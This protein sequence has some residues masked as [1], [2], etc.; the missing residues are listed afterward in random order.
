MF[1]R[2]DSSCYWWTSFWRAFDKRQRLQYSKNEW[3]E[4][5][6]WFCFSESS[7]ANFLQMTKQMSLFFQFK[8]TAGLRP[9]WKKSLPSSQKSSA[10]KI[11]WIKICSFFRAGIDDDCSCFCS[12][13]ESECCAFWWTVSNLDYGRWSLVRL[14]NCLKM[15]EL[16]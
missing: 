11:F 12:Y 8:I 3:T 9:L 13:Y 16:L 15:M 7:F 4:Q 1:N 2:I 10:L 14:S 5:P 6:H